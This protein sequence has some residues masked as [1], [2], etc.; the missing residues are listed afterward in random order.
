[1][2]PR[3]HHHRKDEEDFASAVDTAEGVAVKRMSFFDPNSVVFRGGMVM[4]LIASVIGGVWGVAISFQ[5]FKEQQKAMSEGQKNTR[6]DVDKL[7]SFHY[8]DAE[9]IRTEISDLR[10][11][12][13]LIRELDL[14][15]QAV[16]NQ[17]PG[18]LVMPKPSF[19]KVD[20]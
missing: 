18:K 17:N 9:K 3:Q 5:S 14:W 19:Y 11:R 16:E 12:V 2:A 13:L 15:A 10:K 6:A 7:R 4:A 1:M 20:N 8:E